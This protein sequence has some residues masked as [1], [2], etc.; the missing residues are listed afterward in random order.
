M[1][2]YAD[3]LS[4]TE[5]CGF[6]PS[7]VYWYPYDEM[8]GAEVAQFIDLALWAKGEIPRVQFYATLRHDD[9]AQALPYLDIAQIHLDSSL[10][11][12]PLPP[13]TER[14]LYGTKSPAKSLSPYAY[15]RLMSWL[16]YLKGFKGAGFWAYA[17]AGWGDD[18]GSAWDDFDGKYPDYAVIYQGV[19]RT[20]LSSRR[21]EAWRMGLEDYELLGMYA[22]SHGALAAGMLARR[23]LENPLDT[24]QADKAR[25]EMISALSAHAG[26]PG[27]TSN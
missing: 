8:R 3:L 15:Y 9:S 26:S 12:K 5:A 19:D 14:W 6:R 17:D 7:Q 11:E 27:P 13:R 18:P 2:W 23:I 16:A 1:Q 10:M 4:A 21:W 20:V 22:R 25:Q 24:D